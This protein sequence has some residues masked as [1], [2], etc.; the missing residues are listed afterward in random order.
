MKLSLAH[1][2]SSYVSNGSSGSGQQPWEI[3]KERKE[4]KRR[5]EEEKRRVEGE[6]RRKEMEG[7]T[8]GGKK[9]MGGGGGGLSEGVSEG[10]TEAKRDFF[11]QARKA[12]PGGQIS[13]NK[14]EATFKFLKKK[15]ARGE[16][17]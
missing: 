12:H 6:K 16:V 1:L 3:E 17:L 10:M 7:W 9:T 11:N 2:K 4:E 5:L 8:R 13:S 14:M 15:E